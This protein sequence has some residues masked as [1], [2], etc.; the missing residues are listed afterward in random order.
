MF[1]DFFFSFF[2]VNPEK[3]SCM[4]GVQFSEASHS[5]CHI[6]RTKKKKKSLKMNKVLD[7][8]N[9]PTC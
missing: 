5:S 8:P 1:E 2:F 3:E 6:K 9:P 4:F 7:P